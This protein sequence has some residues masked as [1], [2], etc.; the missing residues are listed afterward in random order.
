TADKHWK[1]WIDKRFDKVVG[2]GSPSIN[3][4]DNNKICFSLGHGGIYTMDIEKSN[5]KEIA[6][7]GTNPKYSPDGTKILYRRKDGLYIMNSD[8][9]NKYKLV[10]GT[11]L[12]IWHPDGKRIFFN[13]YR[14]KDYNTY[15]ININGTGKK[16]FIEQSSFL[17]DWSPDGSRFIASRTMYTA[18]G[19]NI[20]NDRLGTHSSNPKRYCIPNDARFS[21]D[22]TKIVGNSVHEPSGEIAILSS[23]F[24]RIKVLRKN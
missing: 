10:D 23:D 6:K 20:W 9:N 2:I 5:P 12:G 8:G 18:N 16:K 1:E 17:D 7:E 21:P 4:K 24:T 3:P 22:G 15:M 14:K 11:A 13:Y 19:K